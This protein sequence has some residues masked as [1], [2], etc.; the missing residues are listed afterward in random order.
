MTTNDQT[1]ADKR[2]QNLILKVVMDFVVFFSS[3]LY[4]YLFLL[5]LL[6]I[7]HIFTILEFTRFICDNFESRTNIIMYKVIYSDSHTNT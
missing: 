4:Y 5:N 1:K 2:A 3:S 6:I 7:I